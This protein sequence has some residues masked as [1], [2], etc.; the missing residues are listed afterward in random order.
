MKI[1][2]L[3]FEVICSG[4]YENGVCICNMKD[5]DKLKNFKVKDI[6]LVNKS[7]VSIYNE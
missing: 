4:W 6:F 1:N 7:L 3:T 5:D 2:A